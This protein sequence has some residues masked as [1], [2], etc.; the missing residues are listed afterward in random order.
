[1]IDTSAIVFNIIG[2][3]KRERI[4]NGKKVDVA[5]IGAGT[6][7]ID[8]MMAIQKVTENFVLINGGLLGT[9]CARVGCMPSK[10]MIQIADNFHRRHAL[11]G[12]GIR[13][14]DALQLDISIAMD[15]VRALRDGFY[16]GIIKDLIEPLGNKF[17][18]G[19][20][21]FI[22]PNLLEVN[23]DR[24]RAGSTVI[25]TGSRPVIPKKWER[26]SDHIHTTDTV[27]EQRAFPKDIAVIGFSSGVAR[28]QS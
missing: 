24:I 21:A 7:G 25:A 27:F 16:G 17:I 4:H 26:F 5:I 11:A 2:E 12:E 8:A 3:A 14:A 1:M 10:V 15:H 23:A 13:G 22:E 9:T 18:D 19:Y 6:A 20:A 28:G